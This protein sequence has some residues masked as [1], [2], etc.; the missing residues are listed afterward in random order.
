MGDVS[1]NFSRREFACKC[2][3]GFNAVDIGLL[4]GLQALR[5]LSGSAIT[6]TSACRCESHN[7]KVGGA[8]KSLHV[9]AK[10]ADIVIHGLTPREM[11]ALAE[12]VDVFQKG[13]IITYTKKGFIHVDV[14]GIK[15]REIIN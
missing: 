12:R 7:K 5:D 9:K 8:S 10:A 13:A 14:R 4:A 11:A 6:I 3:C 2:G 1:K 15:Y